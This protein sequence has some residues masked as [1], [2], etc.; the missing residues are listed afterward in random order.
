MII[1]FLLLSFLLLIGSL[2]NKAQTFCNPAGNLII[3]SNYDGGIV[4]I[5]VDQNIP[6]LIIA[7]CT[8]EPVQVTITGPFAGNVVQVIY[9]GM[10][11]NQNNNNCGQG[12]FTTSIAGVPAGIV[13]I[14]P[15]MNPS[16]VGYS[17][18]HNN[19]YGFIIGAAGGCDTLASTGGVNTPDEIVYYFENQTGGELYFQY[20][21][22]NCWQNST[23]NISDG[24]NCCIQPAQPNASCSIDITATI[25]NPNCTGVNIGSIQLSSSLSGLTYAW[26]NTGFTSAISNLS[27]G[28]YT[29]TITQNAQCDTIL[30]YTIVAPQLPVITNIDV[31]CDVTATNYTYG[32]TINN[33]TAPYT[34]FGLAGTLTGNNFISNSYPVS[35]TPIFFITDANGCLSADYI[36][37]VNCAVP[38]T[39]NLNGCFGSNL[40]IDGNFESFNQSSPFADFSSDY[41]FNGPCVTGANGCGNYLCQ[42]AFAV[43]NSLTPCNITWSPSIGDHTTGTGNMMVVD[44]P[45]GNVLQK[46]WCAS[47]NLLPNTEYCFGSWFINLLEA[48]SN[49][50]EPTFTFKINGTSVYTSPGID[51]DEQWHFYGAQFNSGAGGPTQLCIYNAD[52]GFL[53]Y[54]VALDDISLK[55]IINGNPPLVVNDT[56]FICSSAP[57]AIVNV[58][59]NDIAATNPIDNSTL[60]ITIA[61]PFTQGSITNI[62]ITNGEITFTPSA[63]FTGSCSFTYKVCD[64]NG[65]CDDATVLINTSSNPVV[66]ANPSTVNIC[67]GDSSL[68]TLNGA[69]NY[70]WNPNNSISIINNN[71]AYVSPIIN[72]TY[73][74]IGT[75]LSTCADTVTVTINVNQIPTVS[76]TPIDTS[77]CFGEDIVINASGASNYTWLPNQNISSSNTPSVV[78]DPIITTTYTVTGTNSSGCSASASSAINIF[79]LPDVSVS[80]INIC[81]DDTATIVASGAISYSWQPNS[82]I[83]S[84]TGLSVDVYPTTN[85]SYTVTGTDTNGCIDTAVSIVSIYPLPVA[86]FTSNTPV[87]ERDFVF[88]D[89]TS[90]NNT[91]NEWNFGDGGNSNDIDPFYLYSTNGTFNVSLI[92]SSA[93]GCSD[94]ATNTVEVFTSA[95][96]SGS[97]FNDYSALNSVINISSL[98]SDS[99]YIVINNQIYYPSSCDSGSVN[100]DFPSSGVYQAY[101]IATNS[102]GC[103]DT[104]SIQITV[105]DVSLIYVPNAFSPNKDGKNDGFKPIILKELDSYEFNIYTRWGNRVFSTNNINKA[106]D[107]MIR[108]VEANLGVYVWTIQYST[109]GDPIKILK[110]NVTLLR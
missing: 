32:F 93:I 88:F 104:V 23:I 66:T 21:Q 3:Y 97:Y 31:N 64:G 69:T 110:G 18:V 80:S 65:C 9:A 89:N 61:P 55:A 53:G 71:S 63:G 77:I 62:N 5:N 68:I 27:P 22:Y 58:L 12:N 52:Y 6:N 25:D 82:F 10:N 67:E 28:T 38:G 39:C 56:T 98:N 54:D 17:P 59:Q 75:S 13:S 105:D 72:T 47:V 8:Y 2:E 57:F 33:G 14:T 76:I 30:S 87:C 51:E 79:V 78:V 109:S 95:S 70:S 4:T 49:Q 44:F 19:G 35:N 16:P 41:T 40:I 1:R 92:A 85:T 36:P 26:S 96:V 15:P 83:T 20:T 46:I 60:S 108:N 11:S 100:F 84:T 102:N 103:S 48:G 107:G 24:G 91:L 45:N 34:I 99:C 73:T 29:V 101:L 43:S 50:G 42:S 81:E 37:T 7:I 86:S 106:W 90:V 94:T 74:V